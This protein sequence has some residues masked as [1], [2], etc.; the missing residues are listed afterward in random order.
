MLLETLESA[1]SNNFF[2]LTPILSKYKRQLPYAPIPR[3]TPSH[4]YSLNRSYH[5][6]IF[7]RYYILTEGKA[8][9]NAYAE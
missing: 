8:K 5:K 7:Q 9:A 6:F 3:I 2:S 1:E 4:S